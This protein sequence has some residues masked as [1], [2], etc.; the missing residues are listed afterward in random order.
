MPDHPP[1]P[2]PIRA[3]LQKRIARELDIPLLPDTAARVLSASQDE[4]SDLQELADLI[5]H[6]QSLAMHVLRIANSAAYAPREPIASLQQAIQRLG[7]RTLRAIAVAVSV[8][9]RVFDVPGHHVRV[10]ALWMHAAAAAAYA[11]EAALL[12]RL[13]AEAA[14]LC[15]LLH[16]IGMPIALQ[17]LCDVAPEKHQP[18]PA[19]LAEAVML[20]LHAEL[21]TRV[22]SAW[23]MGPAVAAAIQW[24]HAP[25]RAGAHREEVRL[26]ALGDELAYWAL[27]DARGEAD[28]PAA[29]AR[30]AALGLTPMHLDNLLGKRGRVLEVTEAFG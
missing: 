22:A 9:G 29:D 17:V 30:V 5:S 19:W 4:D 20:E 1:V 27:D 14:F 11:R 21:G 15:G 3:A 18:V 24:H 6:D 23:R 10:R 8:K 25:A 2:D 16:D 13:D 26:A 7:V 12:L 28:F